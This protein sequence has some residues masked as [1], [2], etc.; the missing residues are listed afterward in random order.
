MESLDERPFFLFLHSYEVHLPYRPAAKF[1]NRFEHDYSG[2]LANRLRRKDVEAIN[3]GEMEISDA[4]LQHIVTL[5][6]AEL[7]SFDETLG[8]VFDFL[9]DSGLAESTVI[10]VVSDHGEEFGEHGT[11]AHHAHTLYNELIKTPLIIGG[12]GVPV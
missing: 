3:S 9:R 12:P 7:A 10:A 6:D 8:R 2:P 5:Y 11:V 1:I 4:D